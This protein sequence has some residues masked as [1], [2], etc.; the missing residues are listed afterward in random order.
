M[1]LH[2]RKRVGYILKRYPR[3]SETFVVNEI[4]AH[5]EA[6]L[7]IVI[8]ALRPPV[9]THFQGSLGRVRAPVRYLHTV[10]KSSEWWSLLH[11]TGAKHPRLWEVLPAEGRSESRNAHQAMEL[12]QHAQSDGITHFHAHFATDAAAVARLTSRITGIPYSI[13]THAKDIFHE[14]VDTADLDAKIGDARHVVTVSDYNL[15]FLHDRLDRTIP[16]LTRIYNGL[17][18]DLFPYSEPAHREP[19]IL[20][21]GRL[22]EKKGFSYL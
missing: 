16:N 19:L 10:I 6:G 12:A 13:T 1:Q 14:T 15:S 22:V 11:E 7:E 21:I 17:D 9:D 3:Y 8:Y 20:G 18:L 5:E 4:L 2:D